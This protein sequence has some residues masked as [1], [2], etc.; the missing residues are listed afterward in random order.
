MLIYPRLKSTYNDRNTGVWIFLW[1]LMVVGV[2]GASGSRVQI[3]SMV[4]KWEPDDVWI[5]SLNLVENCALDPMQQLWGD[6]ERDLDAVKVFHKFYRKIL[7]FDASW[8][9][10]YRSQL[11]YL[12]IFG[13]SVFIYWPV[14]QPVLGRLV[15]FD[16]T[17]ETQEG[18][19][20]E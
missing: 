7:S 16:V 6:A 15:E 10:Q 11:T 18:I 19:G 1:Q 2:I 13:G 9:F 12:E 17:R 8:L 5:Q 4:C 20:K 14:H 3:I